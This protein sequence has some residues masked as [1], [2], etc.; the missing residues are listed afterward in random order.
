MT[1]D[2]RF[3]DVIPPHIRGNMTI[4]RLMT[5]LAIALSPALG[6]GVFQYGLR[7]VILIGCCVVAALG[8]ELLIDICARRKKL[9]AL[10]LH[11]VTVGM[12]I[13]AMLPPGCPL[14]VAIAGASVAI[15]LGK[16]PFG[17]MGGS[18]VS[19]A[20]VG[21]LVLMVSWPDAL[22][23]WQFPGQTEQYNEMY[24]AEP[25]LG[26]VYADPSDEYEYSP[27]SMFIGVNKVGPIGAS[28]GLALT[29]GVLLLVF[30]RI[31]RMHATFGYL[32][33]LCGTALVMGQLYPE[34]P[35]VGFHLTSGYAFLA[36]MFL[37]NDI[38][39]SPVTEWGMLVFGIFS[40]ALTIIL[41]W[42]GVDFGAAI[43]AVAL[44]SLAV[45]FFDRLKP[46]PAFRSE[47]GHGQ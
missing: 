35:A 31:N 26:A 11:A 41:R 44:S 43:Y 10:N 30:L 29:L 6:F 46:K 24:V 13:A 17:A 27:L 36:A 12:L 23:R 38:P 19:P 20:I 37:V 45:P 34:E 32:V 3:A 1:D 8:T 47:V 33:G 4:P 21:M 14:P 15:L 18:F 7:A 5:G 39:T 42:S 2:T 9:K 40:G 16:A 25:P 28:S 22:T